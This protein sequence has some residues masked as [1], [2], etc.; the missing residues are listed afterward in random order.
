MFTFALSLER[1][2]VI[3]RKERVDFYLVYSADSVSLSRECNSCALC[4]MWFKWQIHRQM[5]ST[6]QLLQVFPDEDT[7]SVSFKYLKWALAMLIIHRGA[8]AFCCPP[9]KQQTRSCSKEP[10]YPLPYTVPW[11]GLTTA[12]VFCVNA[13]KQVEC[14]YHRGDKQHHFAGK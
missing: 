1:L 3:L 6:W 11:G 13:H 2:L 5:L 8:S 9:T 12:Q 7:E 10:T 4:F 14:I